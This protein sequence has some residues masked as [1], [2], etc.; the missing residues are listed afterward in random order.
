MIHLLCGNYALKLT[1]ACG[2]DKT[3]GQVVFI[4]IQRLFPHLLVSLF[5]TIF[6]YKF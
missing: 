1:S 5:T 2:T 6:V 4:Y 3:L